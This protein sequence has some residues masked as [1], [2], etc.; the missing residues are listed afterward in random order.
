ML[1]QLSDLAFIDLRKAVTGVIHDFHNSQCSTHNGA[2]TGD[3]TIQR[4]GKL[5]GNDSHGGNGIAKLGLGNSSLAFLL[6]VRLSGQLINQIFS[7]ITVHLGGDDIEIM[8]RA[9]MSVV[10]DELLV[11]EWV[12]VFGDVRRD[13]SSHLFFVIISEKQAVHN[14]RGVGHL[15]L[16]T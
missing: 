6:H 4:L 3:E 7:T 10:M 15:R 14:V 5:L 8:L 16:Q 1:V 12:D 2:T 11:L 13:I 9:A